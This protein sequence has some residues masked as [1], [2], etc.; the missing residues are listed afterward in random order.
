MPTHFTKTD[1]NGT[2][3]LP[4]TRFHFNEVT[5]ERVPTKDEVP[6]DIF[7]LTEQQAIHLVN[8]WN[9]MCERDGFDLT[10]AVYDNVE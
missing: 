10:Y 8:S 1:E 3:T 7:N 9:R 2:E 5:G 6:N 4:F